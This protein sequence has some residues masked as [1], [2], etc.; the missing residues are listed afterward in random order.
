MAM[1]PRIVL[2]AT[3][4]VA[5]PAAGCVGGGASIIFQRRQRI[6]SSD[7]QDQLP[8]SCQQRRNFS[9]STKRGHG[10][11]R[12]KNNHIEGEFERYTFG[13][14][15]ASEH[16]VP[17]KNI[18]VIGSSGVLG[19]TLVS[20]FGNKYAWNVLGA[21]VLH[22]D[23]Q[24]ADGKVGL[25]EYIRLPKEGS[26]ADLTGELYRGVSRHVHGGETNKDKLDAIV[27]AS[28]GW[29]G[30]VDLTS[31]MDDHVSEVEVSS[32]LEDL[33]VEEEYARE[34]ADVC[35]RMMRM[36]YYP[37][38]AGSQIGRRFMKRGGE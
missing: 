31:M 2:R 7:I 19:K 13:E 12:S 22:P 3:S 27:C 32:E 14:D 11:Q 26:M 30:D 1:N 24:S 20:Q 6:S 29:A 36:N 38:V 23:D 9:R 16:Q 8:S 21:D 18:L 35:E 15:D 28:G 5:V 10:N 37:I 33:D 34:S 25:S 4:K 17:N